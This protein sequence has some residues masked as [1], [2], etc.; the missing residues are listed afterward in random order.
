MRTISHKRLAIYISVLL[1][2]IISVFQLL[3]IFIDDLNNWRFIVISVL[4]I[5]IICYV[6]TYYILRTFI[7][8]KIKPIYK[9]IHSVKLKSK[10][11]I[12][13]SLDEKDIIA[14]VNNEVQ[15][16]ADE[17]SKEISQLKA[18]EKY[19]KEFLGNVSHELKTPIFNIQGYVLTLLDGGLEDKSINHLYLERTEKSINRLISIVEDL[20]SIS[21]L[22]SGVLELKYELFNIFSLV[23][24]VYEAHE[25]SAKKKGITLEYKSKTDK[26]LLVNADKKAISQVLNNLVSNSIKYGNENGYIKAGFYDMDNKIL[27]E[28]SDNGIG[29]SQ[30]SLPRIFERFYRVDASRSREQGGTGLG[31]AIVKHIIEAHKQTINVRSKTSKGTAFAFTL[32]KA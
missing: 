5:F 23:E 30:K 7:V 14:D 27:I 6:A 31:L 32:E 29:M 20:E 11:D 24:E 16:W 18:Q 3:F 10:E 22:E 26:P 1:S 12:K 9:A 13:D 19:R 2:I 17:K 25:I 8:N 15:I 21:K 28:V 4:S